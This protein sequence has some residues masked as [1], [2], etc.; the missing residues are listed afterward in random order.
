MSRLRLLCVNDVYSIERF[1]SLK[2]LIAGNQNPN[3][4]TKVILPGD[5][6]GGSKYAA[7][8][9]GESVI[10]VLNCL[11]FDYVTLG[12]HEFDYGCVKTAK[13]MDQ[14]N[15]PW[16]G[17]NVRDTASGKIFHTTI[18]TDTFEVPTS[19]GGSVKVG[20]FGVCTQA[21]PNLAFPTKAVTFEDVL[22]H[23]RRCIASL[24]ERGCDV[25]CAFTHVHLD[26]DKEIAEI[27]G[28]D[29]IIGGH[30]HDP[31]LLIHHGTVIFKCGMNLDYLGILDL[32]L[33]IAKTSLDACG[34]RTVSIAH[35]IQLLSSSCAP[36]SPEIDEI[37]ARWNEISAAKNAGIEDARVCVVEEDSLSSLSSH[38]RARETAF[39]CYVADALW[40]SYMH[41]GCDI[42][43]I[44]GGFIRRN[45]EYVPGT[46]LYRS[47]IMEELPFQRTPVMIAISGRDLRKG[48]EEM[49]ATA[50]HPSGSF[51]H[52]SA[53]FSATYD[54]SRTPMDRIVSVSVKDEPLRDDKV[55]KLAI[56]DFYVRSEGDSVLSFQQ[57]IIADHAVQIKECVQTYL[58]L[59]GTVS[60]TPPGRFVK[61][62]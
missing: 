47:D 10:E 4:L 43:L 58:T 7:D 11:G 41:D 31:Y 37:I 12:N 35:S 2:A 59:K 48:L 27:P 49:V 5:F 44:N 1:S 52:L 50:P 19:D 28:L 32:D 56:S 53:G 60:G 62:E 21:T 9:E 33:T 36:A 55:Y 18:D 46:V 14:S 13:L 45:M 42:G 54:L 25:V 24:K 17:S 3:G 51:P 29:V 34:H 61:I 16:L 57:P 15:F 38:L 20:V 8:H 6:L 39:G 22:V 40:Y 23:S 30:D 26:C